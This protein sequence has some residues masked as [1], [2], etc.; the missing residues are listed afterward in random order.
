MNGN[1][2]PK[3]INKREREI[4]DLL[5]GYKILLSISF[6]EDEEFSLWSNFMATKR[7]R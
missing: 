3:T 4:R 6:N 2:K 7:D 1:F 5:F